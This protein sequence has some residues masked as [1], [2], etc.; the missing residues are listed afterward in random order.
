MTC[1]CDDLE[2]PEF[3]LEEL[4]KARKAHT[5]CECGKAINPGQMYQRITGKWD[6]NVRTYKTC[7][8]CADLRDSLSQVMCVGLEMLQDCYAEYRGPTYQ[9]R[10]N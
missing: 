4:V 9:P 1:G 2:G 5:C 3:Y 7:E 6:G 10:Q 8:P